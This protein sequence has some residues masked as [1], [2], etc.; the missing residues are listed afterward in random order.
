MS[1][2][3]LKFDDEKPDM[4]LLP[5]LATLEVGKVL[6][7]GAKKYNPENW[8]KLDLLQERYTS[9]AMR[10]ILAHMAGEKNDEET[11]LSHLAHAMCCLMFKLE[12][13]LLNA[14]T[15]ETEGLRE[16]YRLEYPESD[17]PVEGGTAYNKEGGLRYAEYSVQYD[18]PTNNNR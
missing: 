3:G 13:E 14:K 8:R 17:N 15:S 7:Y 5:P 2:F 16:S 6:T 11:G 12:D 10:H 18:P 4:Y 1:E 9:A